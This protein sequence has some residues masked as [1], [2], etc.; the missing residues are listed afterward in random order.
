MPLLSKK[1]FSTLAPNF[2]MPRI[3]TGAGV[4]NDVPFCPA[5]KNVP[6]KKMPQHGKKVG[7]NGTFFS[8]TFSIEVNPDSKPD[9]GLKQPC[10][11]LIGLID[12]F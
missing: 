6:F 10:F 9:E 4:Y 5:P 2:M 8:W 11:S 12:G 3:V 1:V 7:Q